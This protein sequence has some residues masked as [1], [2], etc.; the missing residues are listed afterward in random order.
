MKDTFEY[1]ER[2]DR[3][4][5]IAERVSLLLGDI[6]EDFVDP[7]YCADGNAKTV[8]PIACLGANSAYLKVHMA[9]EMN[10]SVW[11]E[12][13]AMVKELSKQSPKS[14][15]DMTN[16]ER[17]A[18][19]TNDITASIRSIEGRV[20]WLERMKKL[21]FASMALATGHD[22]SINVSTMEKIIAGS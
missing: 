5:D 19:I 7:I 20:D 11:E 18:E 6:I 16:A 1:M 9:W 14:H 13:V 17:V 15:R 8:V 2:I 3:L 21:N 10:Q 12:A 22:I 4:S